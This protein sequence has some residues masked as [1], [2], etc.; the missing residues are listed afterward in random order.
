MELPDVI[1]LSERINRGTN[2]RPYLPLYH[3][4]MHS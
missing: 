1:V 3:H 2:T 4:H